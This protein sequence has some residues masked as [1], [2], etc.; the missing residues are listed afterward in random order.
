MFQKLKNQ[1]PSNARG[2]QRQDSIAPFLA[3]LE[4]NGAKMHGCSIAAFEGYGLGIKVDQTTSK[5]SLIM[6]VPSK[7]FMSMDSAKR[8]IL[9]NLLDKVIVNRGPL[10]QASSKHN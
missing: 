10:Y 1:V 7:L 9:K 5:N 3:W 2:A 4:E 6:S 8:S